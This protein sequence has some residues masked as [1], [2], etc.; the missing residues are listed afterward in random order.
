[1][2]GPSSIDD[3]TPREYDLKLL[4]PVPHLIALAY[5]QIGRHTSL[6]PFTG[7]QHSSQIKVVQLYRMRFLFF[8]A[9]STISPGCDTP[10]GTV[11]CATAA[12]LHA[13]AKIAIIPKILD[14]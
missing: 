4:A 11:C 7:V 6:P 14:M 12:G 3:A 13:I 2:K 8:D 1:V 10:S 9:V 5:I